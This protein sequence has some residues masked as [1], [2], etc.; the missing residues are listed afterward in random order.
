MG[1]GR[2][3]PTREG[4]D[5]W[6]EIYDDELNPLVAIEGTKVRDWL[7]D[8]RDLRVLD[9]GCGTGR[10]AVALAGA[11]AKVTGVDFS[12]GM[13]E[14]A[15][16]KPGAEAVRFLHLDVS[17]TLPFEA[18]SFD[19][20]ISCLVLDH[21]R[22]VSGFFR[23]LGRVCRPDGF[24]VAS[25]M[26]PAMM[27]KGVQARFQDPRTEERISPQSVPN[28]ISDYVMGAV[29]AGVEIVRVAE[30]L[31]GRDLVEKAPRAEKYLDWPMLFMMKLAPRS[32][33]RG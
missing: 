33:A 14:K 28:Q 29:K 8:V 16:S 4:Y 5:L 32:S 22:D 9:V 31:V 21:V 23:E 2:I 30:Y 11:E 7:G 18:A 19:R 3:V 25:V 27:L 1:D 17:G 24:I 6:S 20:V 13:L 10:H 15:R 12:E 26:H